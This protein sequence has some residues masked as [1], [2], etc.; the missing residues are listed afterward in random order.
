MLQLHFFFVIAASWVIS[1]LMS[2]IVSSVLF[3]IIRRFILSKVGL[4]RHG[5]KT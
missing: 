3:V 2:G 1:P 4:R 5:I